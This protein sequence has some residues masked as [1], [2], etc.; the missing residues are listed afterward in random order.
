MQPKKKLKASKLILKEFNKYTPNLTSRPK[1]DNILTWQVNG[2]PFER[3]DPEDLMH[4]FLTN[5]SSGLFE[6]M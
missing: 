4:I 3:K 6:T 2:C 1:T 5:L